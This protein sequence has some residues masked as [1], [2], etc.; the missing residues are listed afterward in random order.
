MSSNVIVLLVSLALLMLVGISA[1]SSVMS[2]SQSSSDAN[3][4][5]NAASAQTVISPLYLILGFCVLIVGIACVIG[6]FS[7]IGN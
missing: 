3:V 2:E 6:A 5:G 1:T 7:S 4:S